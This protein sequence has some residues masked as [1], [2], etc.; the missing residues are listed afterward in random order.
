MAYTVKALADLASVT[1]RALHHYDQIGL[2][3]P[4]AFSPTGY[5]LYTQANLERLQHVLFFRELG[6]GLQEIKAIVDSPGFNRQEALRQHR[7]FLLEKRKRLD[8]LIHAVERTLEHTEGGTEVSD[9]EMLGGF[10]NK[11]M[12]EYRVEAS[13][14]WGKEVDD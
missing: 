1:V 10:D 4:A 12:E 13:T 11:Q 9:E 14:R 5:R 6:F 2:L 3:R 8:K 7:R